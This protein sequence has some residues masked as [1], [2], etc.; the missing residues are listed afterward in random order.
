MDISYVLIIYWLV[1]NILVLEVVIIAKVTP[2]KLHLLAIVTSSKQLKS[3]ACI[4]HFRSEL[5]PPPP[6]K[7]SL[8]PLLQDPSG[9]KPHHVAIHRPWTKIRQWFNCDVTL[10]TQLLFWSFSVHSE[11]RIVLND[12]EILRLTVNIVIFR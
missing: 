3:S 8:E 10:V 11:V 7:G 6:G 9:F 12:L 2:Y 5:W 1:V 4:W